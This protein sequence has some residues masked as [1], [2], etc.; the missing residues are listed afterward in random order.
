MGEVF[1]AEQIIQRLMKH[2]LYNQYETSDQKWVESHRG[3]ELSPLTPAICNYDKK[4]NGYK[5]FRGYFS[6]FEDDFE[7]IIEPFFNLI[8]TS[9][10][11]KPNNPNVVNTVHIW[12][13]NKTKSYCYRYDCGDVYSPVKTD[14]IERL[15]ELGILIH[16]VTIKWD[17]VGTAVV[18]IEF[19]AD[20]IISSVIMSTP[21]MET[22][23]GHTWYWNKGP[24]QFKKS[25][26]SEKIKNVAKIGT[27][28]LAG[29]AVGITGTVIGLDVFKKKKK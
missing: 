12:Y 29:V 6:T 23:I 1:Y 26:S 11:D 22:K 13:S 4:Y 3:C 16:T 10:D 15:N 5:G 7:L 9:I 27:C 2:G 28:I 25:K 21:P 14:L 19:F 17:S 18:Y 24:D 8:E 20:P